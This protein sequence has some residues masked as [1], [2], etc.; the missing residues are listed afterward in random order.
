MSGSYHYKDT[1]N[2]YL[3]V[4]MEME[5]FTINNVIVSNFYYSSFAA[6]SLDGAKVAISRVILQKA[7]ET[8]I[9]NNVYEIDAL[10][11]IMKDC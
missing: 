9:S 11:G 3:R 4:N 1:N 5:S 7:T 10:V 8:I 2:D 6:G